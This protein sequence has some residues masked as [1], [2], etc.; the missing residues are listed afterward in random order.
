MRAELQRTQQQLHESRAHAASLQAQLEALVL[1][2]GL[3]GGLGPSESPSEGFDN[4]SLSSAASPC[5][6]KSQSSHSSRHPPV[7]RL[8][9]P[10]WAQGAHHR[11]SEASQ[12][13]PSRDSRDQAGGPKKPMMDHLKALFTGV[14]NPAQA[15]AERQRERMA[16]RLQSWLRGVRQRRRF[17]SMRAIFA[18]I[19]G[20]TL[21]GGAVPAYV[22]TVSRPSPTANSPSQSCDRT[23]KSRPR[24]A[25][26][27]ASSG[28]LDRGV[29]RASRPARTAQPSRRTP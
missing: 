26:R 21:L 5:S 28:V 18:V 17:E 16:T 25:A 4:W 19:A 6:Y 12:P 27:R 8:S 20:S 22:I 24:S 29:P 2:R 23:L 7:T 15:E 9:I 14:T 1:Q 11:S 13:V 10:T 3:S